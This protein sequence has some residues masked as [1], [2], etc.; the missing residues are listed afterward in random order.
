MENGYPDRKLWIEFYIEEVGGLAEQ[1]TYQVITAKD[2]KI[3]TATSRS[4]RP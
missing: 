2:Y 3:T 1:D 4:F